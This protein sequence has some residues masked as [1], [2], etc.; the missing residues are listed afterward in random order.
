M[1]WIL[2]P[3]TPARLRPL[4]VEQN[5]QTLYCS[6]VELDALL[7]IVIIN[8]FG[9]SK[10]LVSVRGVGVVMFVLLQSAPPRTPSCR[11]YN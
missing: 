8:V 3:L 7:S 9:P 5:K 10:R 4:Q 2:V 1:G 11:R 6:F